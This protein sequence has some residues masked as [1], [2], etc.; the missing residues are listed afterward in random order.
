MTHVS[1]IFF[2]CG[3]PKRAVQN[4][5]AG[6]PTTAAPRSSA[7]RAT[8]AGLIS[9][10]AREPFFKVARY[11]CPFGFGLFSYS[12][13][14]RKAYVM[15]SCNVGS[16]SATPPLGAS[17]SVSAMRF[18]PSNGSRA[19]NENMSDTYSRARTSNSVR[20][21]CYLGNESAIF[22]P[23]NLLASRRTRRRA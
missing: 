2:G 6:M 18:H 14:R 15:S 22:K 12:A 5:G 13:E 17:E 1:P 21:D 16:E 23:L 19:A 10:R 20:R 3:F 11:H 9:I 7:L 4:V 8:V